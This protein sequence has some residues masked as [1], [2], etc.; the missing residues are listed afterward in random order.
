MS[1]DDDLVV[2]KRVSG[3]FPSRR[4]VVM[5]NLPA[6]AKAG[7]SA[8][9]NTDCESWHAPCSWILIFIRMT[10]GWRDGWF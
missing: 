1:Q 3:R 8:A 7:D 2:A 10:K 4:A 5:L 6:P 9:M